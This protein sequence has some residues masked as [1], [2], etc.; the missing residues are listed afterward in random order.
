MDKLAVIVLNWNGAELLR[1]FLPQVI[2]NS[3]L[4][5]IS[6][7][8]A[9]NA[10]TDNSIS[11]LTNEFPNVKLLQLDKNFG[12]A[13]GYNRAIQQIEAEYIVLLNSDAA[14]EQNWL[15]PL[16]E[17]MDSDSNIAACAP[18]LLDYKHK[19]YFEYAGAAGGYIDKFGYVF[20]RGRI[21]STIEEDQAQYDNV[22]EV[23]WATGAAL[24]VRRELFLTTGGLDE[25]FFAHMEEIDLCWRLKNQGYKIMIQPKSVVYHLGGATLNKSN[26]RKTYLNF[27]NNLLMMYKNL[28]ED[29]LKSVM[30]KRMMLD[31][32]AAGMMLIKFQFSDFKAVWKAHCDFKKMKNT[33]FKAKRKTEQSLAIKHQ[34]NEMLMKN[35]VWLHFTGKIKKFSEL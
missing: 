3:Q 11:V 25:D 7:W 8:V 5:E 28:S 21:F 6:I 4:A 14:P 23:F 22:E 24:C 26:P 19:N 33:T 12:F 2:A 29:T 17:L 30:H 34:H 27:R 9:D 31:G 18:K 13:G 20:C 10:S 1:E 35:I 15:S 32:L 16:I